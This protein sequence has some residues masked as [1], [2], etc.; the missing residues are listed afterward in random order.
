M[1]FCK[2]VGV[3][4][5]RE[6]MDASLQQRGLARPGLACVTDLNCV[7]NIPLEVMMQSGRRG[8]FIGLLRLLDGE[9]VFAPAEW[10][11]V[12]GGHLTCLS[13]SCV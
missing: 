4:A 1:V 5:Q 7:T 9:H 13:H 2:P 3:K 12:G 10:V 6:W 8:F 11:C